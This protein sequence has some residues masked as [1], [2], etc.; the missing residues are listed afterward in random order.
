MSFHIRA[1][2]LSVCLSYKTNLLEEIWVVV[3][4][5]IPS[6]LYPVF[7]FRVLLDWAVRMYI[8]LLLVVKFMLLA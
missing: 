6:S 7:F 2:C 3:E 1:V 5:E 4:V 8:I